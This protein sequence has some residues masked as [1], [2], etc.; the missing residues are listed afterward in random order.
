MSG[1]ER[2]TALVTG[3]GRNIGRAIALAFARAGAKVGIIVNSNR[4]QGEAVAEEIR[5]A[6]GQAHVAVGDV[7]DAANCKTM[8]EQVI[9]ALGPID[10]LVNNAARRPRQ[11]FLEITPDEWDSV[12]A[13]NLS[14][15][16]YLSRLVLPGM[17]ER[18][19][20]RIINIG[21][22][23]GMKG[24]RLRAHNVACKAGLVGLTKA[25]ALE[26]GIHGITANIVVP[27][28]MNTSR[29]KKDYPEIQKIIAGLKEAQERSD[30][31]IPRPGEP[32]ELANA[33]MFFASDEAAYLTAQSLYV[34]G[35]LFGLP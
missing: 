1:F 25:I 32:E 30:I 23:D 13:S 26:F 8:V 15:I 18:K 5:A 3:G 2:R 7:G 6:G 20:G 34:A 9:A 33:V 29:E 17:V 35:G 19:F 14:S 10:Y 12:V 4:A 28:I 21:G 31:S 22:P 27:G 24:M 16:F 11:S